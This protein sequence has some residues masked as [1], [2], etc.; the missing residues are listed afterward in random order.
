VQPWV[1]C[2]SLV[3]DVERRKSTPFIST[4]SV[5]LP[6]GIYLYELNQYGKLPDYID[7]T[8]P[9][10][11]VGFDKATGVLNAPVHPEVFSTLAPLPPSM[12][13][14]PLIN[15]QKQRLIASVVKSVV[16][17]QHL[18]SNLSFDLDRKLYQKCLRL[19]GLDPETLMQIASNYSGDF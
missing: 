6:L 2:L 19:R 4:S 14:E 8:S 16:A 5:Y 1:V 3:S 9:T 12:S 13:V 7:P 11:P 18:A 15:V 10:S 17:G